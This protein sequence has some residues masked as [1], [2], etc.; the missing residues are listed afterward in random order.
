MKRTFYWLTIIAIIS[1]FLGFIR[2]IIMSYFYGAG[3]Y[4]DIY[5]MASS[6]ANIFGG[7][8][9]TFAVIQIG[10]ASCRERV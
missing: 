3:M 7:W 4:T 10:R 1:K 8:I 6:A 2:E 9:L 5:Q